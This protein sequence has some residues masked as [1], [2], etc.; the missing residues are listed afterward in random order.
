MPNTKPF[1]SVEMKNRIQAEMMA[2]YESRKAEF[3]SFAD[4]VVATA[5]DNDWCRKQ[6]ERV[7]RGRSVR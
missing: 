2:E 5:K 7:R 3:Q 4:F 1:D 6:L